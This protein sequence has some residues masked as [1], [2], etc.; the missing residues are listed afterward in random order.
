MHRQN[1]CKKGTPAGEEGRVPADVD[2]GYRSVSRRASI[3]SYACHPCGMRM[4]L[5]CKRIHSQP[6]R[7]KKRY[8]RKAARI[9]SPMA[10]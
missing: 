10:K 2:P 6:F 4:S 5:G 3:G 7:L 9:I 1:L 8:G